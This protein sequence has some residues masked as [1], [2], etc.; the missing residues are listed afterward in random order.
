MKKQKGFIFHS[1]RI[2]LRHC[3]WSCDISYRSLKKTSLKQK[4]NFKDC[5]AAMPFQLS[6]FNPTIKW[7]ELKRDKS[8]EKVKKNLRGKWEVCRGRWRSGPTRSWCSGWYAISGSSGR[9]MAAYPLAC[10]SLWSEMINQS[11]NRSISH[12]FRTLRPAGQ[13]A[14]RGPY[15]CNGPRAGQLRPAGQ[16]GASIELPSKFIIIREICW[17]A[18]H[19]S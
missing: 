17:L 10:S 18:A 7:T 3:R 6:F 8:T 19:K 14:C 16:M 13:Q 12:R 15:V 1:K 5:N 2:E 4:V 9:R 11:V